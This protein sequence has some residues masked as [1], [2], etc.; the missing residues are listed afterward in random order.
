M[1]DKWDLKSRITFMVTTTMC[2]AFLAT[3]VFTLLSLVEP[4]A[5]IVMLIVQGF[6]GVQSQINTFYFSKKKDDNEKKDI[7]K[8]QT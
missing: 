2:I 5:A 3:L 1:K 4:T 8:D 6:I 7:E